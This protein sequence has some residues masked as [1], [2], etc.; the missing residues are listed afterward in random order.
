M[1]RIALNGL[2]ARPIRTALPWLAR[3]AA[4]L[5]RLGITTPRE[6]LW[7]L[8]FRYDDFSS[9]Q[10]IRDLVPDEK[11]SA[12]VRVDAVRVEP[13]FGKRP[14]RVIAQSLSV[15]RAVF[16]RPTATLQA[17][18]RRIPLYDFTRQRKLRGRPTGKGAVPGAF[19][20]RMASGH[21]GIFKRVGK[22]RSRK[23]LPPHAPGLP[24]TELFGPSLPFVFTN[25]KIMGALLAHAK[26]NLAKNYR[27]E[28]QFLERAHAS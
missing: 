4:G 1:L 23:G 13:G 8:P 14:Q 6:A 16:G 7:Y 28:V 17:T 12:R 11:Q 9:L 20:A 2:L 27:H 3:G 21:V 26:E 18:G 24:I 22:S 15:E 25:A 5:A 10:A 19:I